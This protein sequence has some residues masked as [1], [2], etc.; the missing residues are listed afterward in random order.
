[1]TG[2]E[3]ITTADGAK[4]LVGELLKRGALIGIATGEVE[5]LVKNRLQ[6]AGMYEMFKFGEYGNHHRDLKDV[7]SGAVKRASEFGFSGGKAWIICTSPIMV[8]AAKA[9]GAGAIGVAAGRYSADQLSAAGA[10]LV[11][12]SAGDR[13]KII[14]CIFR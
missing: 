2:R 4:Q 11:V 14:K 12:R 1:M 5:D 13:S 7:V 9:A 8:G 6:R 10:D 3:G